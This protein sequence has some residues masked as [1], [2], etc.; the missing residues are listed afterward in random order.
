MCRLFF[1]Y[2]LKIFEDGTRTEFWGLFRFC[3]SL[4][5]VS[6]SYNI[7]ALLLAEELFE[8]S[9]QGLFHY[10]R[11]HRLPLYIATSF[12]YVGFIIYTILSI[13]VDYTAIFLKKNNSNSEEV[14]SNMLSIF[15]FIFSTFATVGQNV[16]WHYFLYY[17]CPF[18]IWSLVFKI[19]TS[20]QI[21][22]NQGTEARNI[23]K[24]VFCAIITIESLIQTFFDRRWLSIA[25]LIQIVIPIFFQKTS[26][27][28]FGI[29]TG[30]C[31]ILMIFSFQPS[32]GNNSQPLL[33]MD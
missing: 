18:I 10:Q 27:R 8:Q 33:G 7:G 15:G 5:N 31:I 28:L 16:P 19:L 29:W 9:Y 6:R 21:A 23:L 20:V 26:K 13:T 4:L 11:Y 3:I 30:L 2:F 17:I 1:C 24:M 22:P 25:L 12:S 14:K 32:V